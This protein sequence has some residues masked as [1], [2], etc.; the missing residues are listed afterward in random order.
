MDKGTHFYFRPEKP[1][2]WKFCRLWPFPMKISG[3]TNRCFLMKTCFIKKNSQPVLLV[4]LY[5]LLWKGIQITLNAD[6]AFLV[7]FPTGN[8]SPPWI[9]VMLYYLS[10]GV[11]SLVRIQPWD[12]VA[13]SFQSFHRKLSNSFV[14]FSRVGWVTLLSL[15]HIHLLIS[16]NGFHCPLAPPWKQSNTAS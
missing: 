5:I 16:S 3:L 14:C 11:S 13:S 7:F 15:S 8:T 10:K 1:F 12:T 2:W 6:T 4:P 9:P